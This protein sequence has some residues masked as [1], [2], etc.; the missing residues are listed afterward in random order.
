[1]SLSTAECELIAAC[2]A[3]TLAQSL[4]SLVAELLKHGIMKVLQVDNVAAI[5]L[6]EGGVLSVP[7]TSVCALTS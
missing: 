4:E 5:T 3:V 6:A 7:G 1:M 2:E